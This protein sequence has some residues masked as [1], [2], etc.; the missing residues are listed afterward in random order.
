[1]EIHYSILDPT[2]NI[3]ALVESPVW[4]SERQAAAAAIMQRHD[5]VEQAGFL[6]PAGE[7]G[8][9]ALEMAGGEFCGNATMCAAS[10]LA[11]RGL[12]GDTVSLRVSGAKQPVE[13]KLCRTGDNSFRAEL[14]MPPAIEIREHMF[15]FAGLRGRLPLVRMEGISH[16]VVET[17]SP[18]FAL[19][20]DPEAAERAVKTFCAELSADGLGLLFLEGEGKER[21]MTPLVYI[22]GS[23]TVF[24]ENSCASGSA[25][26]GMYLA[27]GNTAPTE[28]S[29]REPG[30]VLHVT[31]DPTGTLLRGSVRLKASHT[32]VI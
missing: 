30:G 31:S 5:D 29:L 1:M 4:A 2:G 17:R 8:L 15:A 6:S 3:T 26:L 10:L 23:G 27:A 21:R 22:P 32:L 14:K 11:L 12:Y 9:P 25:A 7:D 18:F 16:L 20:N 19:L 24:W 13:V 28:L